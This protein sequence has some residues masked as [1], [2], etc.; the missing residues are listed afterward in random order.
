L[1]FGAPSATRT[2]TMAL[3]PRPAH[4]FLSQAVCLLLIFVARLAYL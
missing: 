2:S 4:H 3:R 1:A